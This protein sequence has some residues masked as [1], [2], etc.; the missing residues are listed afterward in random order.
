MEPDRVDWESQGDNVEEGI[1]GKQAETFA[2]TV[3]CP[4]DGVR[5]AE[6]TEQQM[7]YEDGST[8]SGQIVDGKRHGN[9]TC[10]T[11]T[12]HFTGQWKMDQQHGKGEQT[13]TDGRVYEGEFG[14]G[15][16]EGAGKM[17]WH[18]QKGL[19]IYEGQ[20]KADLKHG[21]GKFTF[22]EGRAYDGE[23]LQGKRHGRA[24]YVNAH[25]DQKAG[26]WSEDKF[27]RW[28]T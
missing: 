18:T 28:E 13:W 4:G 12:G 10:Q 2:S 24:L 17:T 8:Y 16:F 9:G 6:T 23:W 11:R 21:V 20:Y 1:G 22:P 3:A 5:K 25:G 27:V 7:T 15:R 19:L 26:Y 14:F